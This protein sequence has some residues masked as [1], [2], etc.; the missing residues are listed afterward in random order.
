MQSAHA[1]AEQPYEDPHEAQ[2]VVVP[3]Q[4]VADQEHP[5]SAEHEVEDGFALH[6]VIVPLQVELQLQ[7]YSAEHAVDVVFA[8]HGVIVPPHVPEFQ[9][10]PY[11]YEHKLDDA[12]DAHG[13]SVPVQVVE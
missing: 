4:P 6:G 7:P 9:V 8:A 13:V 12:I 3:T 10:Q 2:L 1:L 5:L 11:W